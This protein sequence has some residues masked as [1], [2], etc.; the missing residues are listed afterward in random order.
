[1]W[2]LHFGYDAFPTKKARLI[3]CIFEKPFFFN[4]FGVATYFYYFL[5]ENKIR[6]K[7]LNVTP[8]RKSKSVKTEVRF[9]GQVTYWE[10]TVK[11]HSTPLSPL[12]VGSLIIKLRQV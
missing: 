5:R 4:G 12:K 6:K 3:F 10:G 7:T 11:I 9:G 1:M 2:T 8:N